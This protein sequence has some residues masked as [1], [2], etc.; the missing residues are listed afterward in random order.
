MIVAVYDPDGGIKALW[1]IFG[2]AN[3]LLAATAL[4][5]ATTVILKMALRGGA[6]GDRPPKMGTPAPVRAARELGAPKPALALVTLLPLLWLLTVTGTAAVQKIWDDDPRIGFLAQAQAMSKKLE[7]L[8][9]QTS[10]VPE[11]NQTAH[12]KLMSQTSKQADNAT[13]DAVVTGFFLI[14]VTAIFL[15]S[16]REWI[17]LLARKKAA[18]PRETT[19]TW[20]PEYAVA[21]VQPLKALSL[22]A[23]AAALLKELSGEAAVD[24]AQQ[25]QS[26]C[27]RESQVDLLAGGLRQA[28]LSRSEAYR[29]AADRRFREPSRCC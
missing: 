19:P 20:L 27:A 5:L 17:L 8:K 16:V 21:E 22:L 10:S 14:L 15:L 26:I 25:G 13:L 11:A 2:I 28:T 7:A 6:P 9:A 4:C 1:P 24:R 18:E 23:L 12:Q 3:Q 29:A